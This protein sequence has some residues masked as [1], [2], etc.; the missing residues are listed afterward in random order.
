MGKK[1]ARPAAWDSQILTVILVHLV[2]CSVILRLGFSSSFFWSGSESPSLHIQIP[3]RKRD[4]KKEAEG[5]WQL[6][7]SLK[8]FCLFVLFF[9]FF[10]GASSNHSFSYHLCAE[11]EGRP[12]CWWDRGE[13]ADTGSG[14]SRLCYGD[15]LACSVYLIVE[16]WSDSD[17]LPVD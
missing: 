16:I 13:E 9:V 15:I 7:Q 3:G 12:R 6:L 17:S 8:V 14:T 11:K 10:P 5:E 1:L 2:L 4:E